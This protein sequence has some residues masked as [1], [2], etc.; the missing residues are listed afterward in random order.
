MDAASPLPAA[1]CMCALSHAGAALFADRDVLFFPL[2]PQRWERSWALF[3]GLLPGS[4]QFVLHEQ[5]S[6]RPSGREVM[7][8]RPG[9]CCASD[10]STASKKGA[11]RPDFWRV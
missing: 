11:E 3:P 4:V 9:S 8:W 10:P 2:F 1:A 5:P 7:R 6:P